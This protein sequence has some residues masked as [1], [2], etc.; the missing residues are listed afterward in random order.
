[1]P[2]EV[3]E[4]FPILLKGFIL[5]AQF[6]HERLKFFFSVS[7]MSRE[8]PKVPMLCLWDLAAATL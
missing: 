7:G 6:S 5:F 3:L 8:R 2:A 4:P 1:L